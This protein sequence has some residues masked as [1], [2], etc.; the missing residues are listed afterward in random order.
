MGEGQ[1][2]AEAIG[3]FLDDFSKTIAILSPLVAIALGWMVR[4][5]ER[6]QKKVWGNSERISKLEGRVTASGEKDSG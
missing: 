6:L 2:L 1:E 4:R 5:S 3:S